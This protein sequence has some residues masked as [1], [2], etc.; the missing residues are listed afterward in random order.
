MTKKILAIILGLALVVPC[1]ATTAFAAGEVSEV[2]F[3]LD[4]TKATARKDTTLRGRCVFLTEDGEVADKINGFDID[5]ATF[6]IKSSEHE[7]DIEIYEVKSSATLSGT[8]KDSGDALSLG[9]VGAKEFAIVYKKDIDE[10][11]TDTLT[12]TLEKGSTKFTKPRSVTVGLPEANVYVVRTGGVAKPD[13]LAEIPA[14]NADNGAT[15]KKAGQSITV[16]VFAAFVDSGTF[17]YTSNVPAGAETASLKG[18]VESNTNVY[19]S[20]QNVT[21]VDGHVQVTDTIKDLKIPTAMNYYRL[22][23]TTGAGGDA[24]GAAQLTRMNAYLGHGVTIT[25]KAEASITREVGKSLDDA[26]SGGQVVISKANVFPKEK[27]TSSATDTALLKPADLDAVRMVGLPVNQSTS[28]G[29]YAGL[30]ATNIPGVADFRGQVSALDAW[31]LAAADPAKQATSF[32]VDAGTA[33]GAILGYDEYENPAPFKSSASLGD[34]IELGIG[35]GEAAQQYHIV[36]SGS[37]INQGPRAAIELTTT[38]AF[39]CFLPFE[40]TQTIAA[41]SASTAA[42]ITNVYIAGGDFTFGDA[43]NDIDEE[44]EGMTFNF[45]DYFNYLSMTGSWNGQTVNSTVDLD[46]SATSG[47]KTTISV[48]ESS[49]G[50]MMNLGKEDAS[51]GSSTFSLPHEDETEVAVMSTA[52]GGSTNNVILV[53]M[54]DSESNAINVYPISLTTGIY[55]ADAGDYPASMVLPTFT[56]GS[57]IVDGEDKHDEVIIEPQTVAAG[58]S[59]TWTL[60]A[61]FMAVDGLGNAY[62]PF[63]YNVL[64][65][66]APSANLEDAEAEVAVML[67]SDNGSAATAFPGADGDIDGNNVEL[68]FNLSDITADQ[69]VAIVK[70]TAGSAS[71]ELTLNLNSVTDLEVTTPFVPVPNVDDT[72]MYV[73]FVN[74][75]GDKVSPVTATYENNANPGITVEIEVTDEDQGSITEPDGGTDGEFIINSETENSTAVATAT[76]EDGETEMTVEFGTK[77]YGDEVVVLDFVPDF[78]APVVGD[79]TPT[80]CGFEIAITDNKK[81]DGAST[82]VTVVSAGGDDLTS[83]LEITATDNNTSGVVLVKADPALQTGTYSVTIVAVDAASNESAS[84]TKTVS[85]TECTDIP[86][87]CVSVD[88]NYGAPGETVTVTITGV[89]TS[90]QEGTTAVTTGCSGIT[91]GTPTVASTTSLQ[92]DFT[93][94][95]DAVEEEC[96]VTVTTDSEVVACADADGFEVTSVDPC[97]DNDGDGYGENCELGTDCDDN[98]TAVNPGA[99]EICDGIDND[100]DGEIDEGDVCPSACQLT[101]TPSSVNAGIFL[102]RLRIITITGNEEADFSNTSTLDMGSEIT[103]LLKIALGTDRMLAIVLVNGGATAGTYDVTVDDCEGEITIN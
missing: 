47:K 65:N 52:P 33:F 77:N 69:D 70:V 39:Q 46:G 86:A 42:Q 58:P 98:N 24:D 96:D 63:L 79:L 17:Y 85:I 4:K 92:V 18:E 81:V 101:L 48:V 64:G 38:R 100:C 23:G 34:N 53:K 93:I 83:T 5:G 19:A 103:V 61:A 21:L 97:V 15:T 84:V 8:V 9:S 80:N 76:P 36:D 31:Y 2:Y 99:T 14:Q 67:P 51:S 72:P 55:P 88:P 60:S 41:A 71:G 50:G 12:A 44:D 10:T 1:F 27:H 62:T 7:N 102:P 40:V 90:F 3:E 54:Q 59:T 78:E 22:I 87:G 45:K 91:V 13:L 73:M 32:K 57:V 26:N 68:S 29:G 74:Q 49:T 66:T 35:T 82:Q 89:E 30:M 75:D 20:S 43:D 25:Y 95:A 16:D 11:G 56:E 94:A 37:G 6:S 28:G